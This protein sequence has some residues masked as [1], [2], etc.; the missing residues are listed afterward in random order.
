MLRVG[1]VAPASEGGW[2]CG[3]WTRT[4][5]PE[6]LGRERSERA[7]NVAGAASFGYEPGMV[8]E[9]SGPRAADGTRVA[10]ACATGAERDVLG[11]AR[12]GTRRAGTRRAG[13]RQVHG[14]GPC[15][16]Y[17]GMVPSVAFQATISCT[18]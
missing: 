16:S 8:G 11:G 13:T 15:A 10:L 2:S 3:S 5:W 1:A 4:R 9:P 17:W 6:L 12:R 18:A 7:D 14:R